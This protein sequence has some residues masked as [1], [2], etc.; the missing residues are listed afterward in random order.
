MADRSRNQDTVPLS[1]EARSV[2]LRRESP[3]VLLSSNSQFPKTLDK[4]KIRKRVHFFP[5]QVT[6]KADYETKDR[7]FAYGCSVKVRCS[8]FHISETLKDV[9]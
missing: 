5:L 6:L 9:I 1:S 4:L 8:T 2:V 3:Q 7:T